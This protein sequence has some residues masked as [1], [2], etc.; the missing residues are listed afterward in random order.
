MT[1]QQPEK[2]VSIGVTNIPSLGATPQSVPLML[3][4]ATSSADMGPPMN[5]LGGTSNVVEPTPMIP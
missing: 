2:N 1:Q 3:T 5:T 4:N